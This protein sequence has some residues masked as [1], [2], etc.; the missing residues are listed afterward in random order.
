LQHAV[1]AIDLGSATVNAIE[2]ANEFKANRTIPVQS[3]NVALIGDLH[4]VMSGKCDHCC[5]RHSII[6]V[7]RSR[8]VELVG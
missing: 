3:G 2:P 7:M 4:R 5:R 1:G 8:F 6:T